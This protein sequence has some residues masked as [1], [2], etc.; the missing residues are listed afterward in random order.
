MHHKNMNN[1][2]KLQCKIIQNTQHD[3]KRGTQRTGRRDPVLHY[4]ITN[5]CARSL[6]MNASCGENVN[7]FT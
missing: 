6:A 1:H 5:D 3:M 7:D 4:I 2:H